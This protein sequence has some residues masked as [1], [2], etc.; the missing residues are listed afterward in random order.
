MGAGHYRIVYDPILLRFSQVLFP[1]IH[2]VAEHVVLVFV[3]TEIFIGAEPAAV[4]E[5]HVVR[6]G[7]KLT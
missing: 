7:N 6:S 3:S 5:A 1:D 2:V 4:L